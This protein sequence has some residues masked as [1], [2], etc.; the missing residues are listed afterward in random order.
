MSTRAQI[1]V[2]QEGLDWGGSVLLYH[3]CDGYPSNIIPLIK[4]AF[5]YKRKPY[6]KDD[7]GITWERGRVGK[8]ASLLCWADPVQFE[9]EEGHELHGDIEYYYRLYAVNSNGGCLTELPTWEVEIFTSHGMKKFWDDAR[10]ENMRLILPRTAL[11]N[12]DPE[13]I[14]E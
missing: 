1:Q 4:K 13:K 10:L 12:I 7:K 11:E 8:V 2:V 5:A 3:H 9:P 14:K 6:C